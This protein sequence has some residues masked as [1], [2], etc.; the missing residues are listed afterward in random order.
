MLIV[1]ILCLIPITVFF[2]A[3]ISTKNKAISSND[4]SV[5]SEV[6]TNDKDTEEPKPIEVKDTNTSSEKKN[7]YNSPS[8][9][10]KENSKENT[11]KKNNEKPKTPSTNKSGQYNSKSLGFAIDFPESWKGHYEV[12]EGTDFLRVSFKP[13]KKPL[14]H[15]GEGVLF[16]ILKKTPDLNEAAYDTVGSVKHFEAKG[17]TYLIGGPLDFSME[18]NHP[19]VKKYMEM[20]KERPNVLKTIK[21]IK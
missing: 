2:I 16:I 21:A 20:M 12:V 10:T 19:E 1:I 9:K 11:S 3:G 18:E 7:N 6:T 8:T 17:T 14:T 4:N 13:S 15:E 5:A